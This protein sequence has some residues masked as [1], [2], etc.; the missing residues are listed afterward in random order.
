MN[1]ANGSSGGSLGGEVIKDLSGSFAQLLHKGV[2]HQRV[3]EGRGVVLRLGKL[4]S[5][6]IGH[7][8]AIHAQHLSELQ[9]ASLKLAEG[10]ISL[11]CRDF[12]KGRLIIVAGDGFPRFIFEVIHS[13]LNTSLCKLAGTPNFIFWDFGLLFHQA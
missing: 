12:M 8:V 2:D 5:V 11:A 9:R 7:H 4:I 3:G 6:L 13:N 10:V 1:L